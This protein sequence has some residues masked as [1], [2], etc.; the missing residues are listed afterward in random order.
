[1]IPQDKY[2]SYRMIH[3]DVLLED[4][5]EI[6]LG[7]TVIHCVETVGHTEGTM[8]FFFDVEDGGKVW[9]AGTFGGAGFITMYKEFFVRY[10][11]P[12]LQPAFLYSLEL[13]KQ[14]NVQLVLG[15][16]PAPNHILQKMEK[17]LKDPEGENPFIDPTGQDWQNYLAWVEAEFHQFM[18]DGR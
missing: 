3:P 2:L 11:L 7:N 12:D 5:D 15:N 14:Q 1:M 13:M 6:R 8:S 9:H 10:G 16:H 17:L 4:G 18:A